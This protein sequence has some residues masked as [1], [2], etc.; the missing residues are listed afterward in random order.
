M[1]EALA[2][3]L[4]TSAAELDHGD[5]LSRF[6]ERFVLDDVLYLDG[7]SLGR[8]PK[9][10]LAKLRDV[11]E[12][13]WAVGLIASWDHWIDLARETGDA[14]GAACLGAP[15]GTTMVSDSTSINLAK[16]AAAALS[17][18][19]GRTNIVVDANDF[20]TD[21]YLMAGLATER[22]GS[23]VSLDTS[24]IAGPQAADVAAACDDNTALVVLSHVNYRSG[25]I[26]DMAAI[27]AAAHNAGAMIL[28]DLS[29]SVG[30]VPVDLPGTGPDLA[31]GCTYKYLN[32][33]PG[34]PAFL[35]VRD[36]LISSLEPSLKGWFG[37]VAQFDMG[38]SFNPVDNIDRF[39][40]GTP[41]LLSL[42]AVGPAIEVIADA[43]IEAMRAKS[44]ALTERL[45]A[46][47]DRDLADFG[48]GIGSPRD[49]NQ[50]GGH[51]TLTHPL[52]A[53]ISVALRSAG[54]VGDFR[55]PD[56]LRLAP[57]PLYTRFADVDEAVAR[58]ASLVRNGDHLRVDVSNRVS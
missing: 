4:A 56:G 16:M 26:A 57:V 1:T 48:F 14:I 7:N 23:L 35:Y 29:H 31:V 27:T 19:R 34:S 53:Q 45:V 46:L 10:S 24:A 42:C 44:V 28:W 52:A 36:D 30:S 20:P 8:A 41:P 32:G 11:A 39:Q 2:N 6:R 33:G 54:V 17:R 51:V 22:R 12:N 18:R 37:T 43:G 47:A 15:A 3:P 55:K 13:E 5:P 50:R 25:A 49:P 58:I 21:R 40:V 38:P 9:A